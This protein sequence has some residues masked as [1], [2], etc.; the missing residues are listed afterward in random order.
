VLS[1]I[2][3]VQTTRNTIL[4]LT[5]SNFSTVATNNLINFKTLTGTV[6][7]AA[8]NATATTLTV[9]VPNAA[10]SGPVSVKVNGQST[11]AS[12]VLQITASITGLDQNPVTVSD[13]QTSLGMDIY[14]PPPAGPTLNAIQ[15]STVNVGSSN[16]IFTSSANLFRGQTT[17]LAISGT[18]MTLA[19][20]SGISFGGDGLTISNVRYQTSGAATMI[21]VTITVDA[22]ASVGPSNIG[23]KNSNLDQTILAGGIF[24]R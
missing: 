11:A 21:I 9:F 7:I 13:G 12:L 6:D 18:G 3:P 22:N 8:L 14:V 19:N 23:I 17:D 1:A 16:F 10:I 24:V 4:T 2:A 5:G 15:V 20:G